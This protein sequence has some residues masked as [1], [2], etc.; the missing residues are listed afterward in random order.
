MFDNI[1]IGTI[2][3]ISVSVLAIERLFNLV[4]GWF[5][6]PAN[7]LKKSVDDRLIQIEHDNAMM[8]DVVF[9][10]LEHEVTNDHITDMQELYGRV[11]NYLITKK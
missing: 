10:L 3:G 6:A 5:N 4:V 11:K 9:S 1:T 7:K 2:V 8:L